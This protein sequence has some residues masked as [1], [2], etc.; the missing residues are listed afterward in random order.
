MHQLIRCFNILPTKHPSRPKPKQHKVA[1]HTHSHNHTH[2][3]SVTWPKSLSC[4][5]PVSL[6][7]STVPLLSILWPHFFQTIHFN[8]FF[9]ISKF[10][11]LHKN[12]EVC[13]DSSF[14]PFAENLMCCFWQSWI[15]Y[16][17]GSWSGFMFTQC[18]QMVCDR[19]TNT[20]RTWRWYWVVCL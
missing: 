19:N 7:N 11:I 16:F 6:T 20:E 9:S 2:A 13:Y 4:I 14:K 1:F 18:T 15:I 12:L 3:L 10:S 17:V 8:F 5:T